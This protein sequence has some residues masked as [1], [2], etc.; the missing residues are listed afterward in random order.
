MAPPLSPSLLRSEPVLPPA[1]EPLE[2]PNQAPERLVLRPSGRSQPPGMCV[3]SWGK[4]ALPSLAC[5]LPSLACV[6]PWSGLPWAFTSESAAGSWKAGGAGS[7]WGGLASGQSAAPSWA[8]RIPRVRRTSWVL[9]DLRQETGLP[10]ASRTPPPRGR[11]CSQPCYR[12][13]NCGAHRRQGL[14]AGAAGAQA[15]CALHSPPLLLHLQGRNAVPFTWS[16]GWQVLTS[17][18]LQEQGNLPT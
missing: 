14:R 12:R 8:E 1:P 5:A 2:T 10:G 17:C 6:L 15:A 9:P 13:G 11:R 4:G 18:C 16:T 7:F 3:Y